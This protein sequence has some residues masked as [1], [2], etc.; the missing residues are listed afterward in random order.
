MISDYNETQCATFFAK[1]K[2]FFF[3]FRNFC[4]SLLAHSDSNV[5]LELSR[6]LLAIKKLM[7]FVPGLSLHA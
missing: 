1:M 7:I 5:L 3:Y 2:Y 4:L 6:Y